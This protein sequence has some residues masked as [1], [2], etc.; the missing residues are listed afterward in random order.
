VGDTDRNTERRDV[1]VRVRN[2]RSTFQSLQ[3]TGGTLF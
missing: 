3:A 1:M 2:V